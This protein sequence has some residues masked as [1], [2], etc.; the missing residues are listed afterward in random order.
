MDAVYNFPN[1]LHYSR[2][3]VECKRTLDLIMS[4]ITK[5]LQIG[6]SAL[7]LGQTEEKINKIV[8]S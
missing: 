5:E 7:D 2:A 8:L 4:S 3:I 1:N 6:T